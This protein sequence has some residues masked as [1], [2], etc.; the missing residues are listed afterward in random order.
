MKEHYPMEYTLSSGTHVKVDKTGVNSYE[1]HLKHAH[2]AE[3][4]FTYIDDDR[5]KTEWDERLEFEQLD[6]LRTFWLKTEDVL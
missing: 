5:P 4:Q 2:G 6:A 3:E 1:F